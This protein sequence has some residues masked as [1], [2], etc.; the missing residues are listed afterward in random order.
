MVYYLPLRGSVIVSEITWFSS[1]GV[2]VFE[3]ATIVNYVPA[4]IPPPEVKRVRFLTRNLVVFSSRFW[5]TNSECPVHRSPANHRALPRVITTTTRSPWKSHSRR[6]RNSAIVESSARTHNPSLL[7]L[8]NA[9]SV[10]ANAGDNTCEGFLTR[11][12]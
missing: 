5:G 7:Q 11:G 9:E 6:R 1:A 8:P 10:K 3:G 2:S 4:L 12:S